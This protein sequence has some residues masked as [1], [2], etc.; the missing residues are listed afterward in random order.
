MSVVQALDFL[1][2]LQLTERQKMISAQILKEI[3]ARLGFLQSVG[4]EYLTLCKIRQHSFRWREPADS[5]S[6]SNW[7]FSHGCSLLFWM[8]P[9]IGL[10]QKDNHKLLPP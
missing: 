3:R 10:H 4:L 6:N 7:F 8:N 5:S 2:T 1:D 9:S